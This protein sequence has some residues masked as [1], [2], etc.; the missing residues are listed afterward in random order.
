M[1]KPRS[2]KPTARQQAVYDW[3][4]SYYRQERFWPSLESVAEHFHFAR[5]S[6]R[7]YVKTLEKKGMLSRVRGSNGGT[8]ARAYE[9]FETPTPAGMPYLGEIS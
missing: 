1:P 4:V 3:M 6:A 5:G 8:L 9:F 2:A 7:N